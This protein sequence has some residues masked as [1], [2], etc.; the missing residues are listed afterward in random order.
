[1]KA[2]R[3]NLPKL[4]LMTLSLYF[5]EWFLL[6]EDSEAWVS[7]PRVL[8]LWHLFFFSAL[9]VVL[10]PIAAT[11]LFSSTLESSA[12]ATLILRW[13]ECAGLAAIIPIYA[14]LATRFYQHLLLTGRDLRFR[15]VALFWS[16]W[17]VLFGK[18]YYALYDLAP[19]S[20]SYQRPLFVPKATLVALPLLLRYKM[21]G[22]FITYS[23][24]VATAIS[25]PNITSDS[26][27]ASILNVAEATGSI[28]FIALI[29]ATFAGKAM[30]GKGK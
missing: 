7:E 16:G 18:L 20:I 4:S 26:L 13:W 25:F 19:T 3:T 28:L 22:Y 8:I 12:V 11:V 27:V 29:V 2:T 10:V 6:A 5:S 15:S 9:V 21:A 24:C 17:I 14:I 1:M 23:A 30:S